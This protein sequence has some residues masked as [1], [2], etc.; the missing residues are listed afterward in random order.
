MIIDHCSSAALDETIENSSE[1]RSNCD[2]GA[3]APGDKSLLAPMPV[4]LGGRIS[5]GAS[6]PSGLTSTAFVGCIKNFIHNGEAWLFLLYDSVVLL[7]VLI[8]IQTGSNV[9]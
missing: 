4:Q 7:Q 1:D 2:F 5:P 8:R 9:K 3:T 6:Y